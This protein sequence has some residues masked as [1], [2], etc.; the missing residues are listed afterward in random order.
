MEA[1]SA[2]RLIFPAASGPVVTVRTRPE[3]GKKHF[4]RKA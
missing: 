4:S 3:N 1:K 2:L